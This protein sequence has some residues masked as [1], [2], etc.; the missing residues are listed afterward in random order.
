MNFEL[1]K[2]RRESGI[3][4]R[5]RI[6]HLVANNFNP[7]SVIDTKKARHN[8]LCSFQMLMHFLDINVMTWTIWFHSTV[9]PIVNGWLKSMMRTQGAADDV[10]SVSLINSPPTTA[11]ADSFCETC[12]LSLQ[13][14]KVLRG[15][16]LIITFGGELL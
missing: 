14:T 2:R 15:D 6:F 10:W 7:D 16:F 4:N 8:S 1:C 12:L 13:Q 11:C 5:K 9:N 3:V